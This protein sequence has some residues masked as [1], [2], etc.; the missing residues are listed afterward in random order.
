MQIAHTTIM[1]K[2]LNESVSFYQDILGLRIVRDLRDQPDHAIVFLSDDTGSVN[3]ELVHTAGR[4]YY[5]GGISIGFRTDDLDAAFVRMQ[6]LGYKPGSV[7]SPNPRTSF[8]F[9][10]DPDGLDIQIIQEH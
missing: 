7:I 4:L 2:D 5:G 10:K 9:I 1:V 3:I 6:E 8:F